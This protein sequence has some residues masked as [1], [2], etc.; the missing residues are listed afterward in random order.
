MTRPPLSLSTPLPCDVTYDI[1]EPRPSAI[2]SHEGQRSHVNSLEQR[3]WERGYRPSR[4]SSV[5]DQRA[6]AL[7]TRQVTFGKVHLVVFSVFS[8]L[9]NGFLLHR[10]RIFKRAC[11]S[12]VFFSQHLSEK[13]LLVKFEAIRLQYIRCNNVKGVAS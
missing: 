1:S 7:P 11:R 9:A 6:E 5:C 13:F 12:R 10:N 2:V 8:S 4:Q 3:A